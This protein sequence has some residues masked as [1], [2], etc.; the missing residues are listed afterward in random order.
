MP[1]AHAAAHSHLFDDPREQ[2]AF[3][4][5]ADAPDS[6]RVATSQLR[7]AGIACAACAPLIEQAL[8]AGM[9]LIQAE[10]ARDNEQRATG[11]MFRRTMGANEGMLFVFEQP[12]QQCFWMRNTLLPLAVAFIAD[13]GAVVNLDEMKPQT[14]AP[15]CSAQPV[16]FVL[17]MNTGWFTKRGIK[18]GFKLQ[19]EPFKP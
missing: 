12:G 15:H 10:L 7:I 9:H 5:W 18:P 4:R 13:D 8:R 11:M 19:G 16:R 14:D 6:E 1:P 17:E 2:I 3:T